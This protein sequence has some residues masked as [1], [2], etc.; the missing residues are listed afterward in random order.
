MGEQRI[1]ALL[2]QVNGRPRTRDALVAAGYFI[3]GLALLQFGGFGLWPEV[4]VIDAASGFIA[5]LVAMCLVTSL[6]SSHPFIV[7][8][9]GVP[10][11]VADLLLGGSLAIVV[12]MA[13]FVY[14]AFRYGGDRGVRVLLWLVLA[15]AVAAVIS[16]VVWLPTNA[17]AAGIALQWSLTV[18]VGGLW[19]W[20]VR[21]ERLA[22]RSAMSVRHAHETERLRQRIAHELHDHVANHIAV[23]GLH[24]EAARLRGARSDALPAEV[25]HS[26]DQATEGTDQAHRRLRQLIAV[27]TTMSDLDAQALGAP[28]ALEDLVPTGRTLVRQ[29]RDLDDVLAS[30][31]VSASEIVRR[32]VR[33][34]VVNAV[35]HGDGD[36]VLEATGNEVRI[37]NAISEGATTPGTGIGVTGA[38]L[39]LDDLGAGL[40]SRANETADQWE[41][42]ISL[43]RDPG[44]SGDA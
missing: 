23:A 44:G 3:A 35:K 31:D 36:T 38:A 4:A 18:L 19:G 34:L 17:V 13:D 2:R 21:S 9:L 37:T 14:C 39:L 12:I 25:A 16:L 7:L 1:R 11:A 10:I 33:E 8:A 6:R 22:T 32:A 42:V 40:S 29:G 43:P 20:T 41:A 28:G 27:L 30:Y 5:V 26:L 24:I 15:L